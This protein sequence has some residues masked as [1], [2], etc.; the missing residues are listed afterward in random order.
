MERVGAGGGGG[1]W[2]KWRE[3]GR[4]GGGHLVKM[5]RVGAGGGGHLVKMERVGAGGGGIW[6][7]WRELGR[8]GGGVFHLLSKKKITPKQH[9][10]PPCPAR[11]RAAGD[12]HNT[13]MSFCRVR[14]PQVWAAKG[15]GNTGITLDSS[16]CSEASSS[17]ATKR[18]APRVRALS[19]R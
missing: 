2:L 10:P 15:C 16:E 14:D 8:G 17:P 1:I 7:K 3:L 4:G 13:P 12:K 18:G 11:P 5:E 6:L 19:E 9:R